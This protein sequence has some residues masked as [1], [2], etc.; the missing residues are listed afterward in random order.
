MLALISLLLGFEAH[1]LTLQERLQ[2]LK[3]GGHRGNYF[4]SHIARNSL[5][6]FQSGIK[7]RADILEMDLQSSKDGVVYVFH[8]NDMSKDT[9]CKG[10]ITKK[11][12][13]EIEQCRFS[14]GQKL[15]QFD[16]VVKTV[17]GRAIIDAEFK[18]L[19]VIKPSIDIVRKYAAYDWIYFQANVDQKKYF[20]ARSYDLNVALLFAP[21]DQANLDWALA[22]N[23]VNLVVIEFHSNIRST[24]NI[25]LVH[26]AG[27]FASEN[28]WADT[29]SDEKFGA[30][31]TWVY[32]AGMDIAIT[33]KPKG[34]AK[35]R[36]KF[37]EQHS[38]K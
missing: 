34:C 7:D 30:S 19:R 33:N 12:A 11:L 3:V 21:P 26:Q 37:V 31:C 6:A 28:S 15:A 13:A 5:E 20:E 35:Q 27:K 22:L 32:E 10:L 14:E 25:N 8:S 2:G 4:I 24:A 36:D 1:A 9:T 16:Q 23:D 18:T 17:A 29:T 38:K